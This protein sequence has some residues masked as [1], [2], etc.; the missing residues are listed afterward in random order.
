RVVPGL[1]HECRHYIARRDALRRQPAPYCG[2][3]LQGPR[4]RAAPRRGPR[5]ARGGP[6]ALDQGIPVEDAMAVYTLHLP[7]GAQ[8]GDARV[9]D[10]AVIVKDGIAWW[11]LI[12]P[13]V[14]FLWNRL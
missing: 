12:F 3:L 2:E 4:P 9:L 8:P 7:A 1:R 5:S 13:L 14:W 10:E 6:R 11:A